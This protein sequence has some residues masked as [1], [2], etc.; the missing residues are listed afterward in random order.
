MFGIGPGVVLVP[1]ATCADNPSIDA[2]VTAGYRVYHWAE[3][4]P[5]GARAQ[6]CMPTRP[7]HCVSMGT[8]D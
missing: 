1:A 4:Q 3:C 8:R 2:A 7:L 6:R 5:F